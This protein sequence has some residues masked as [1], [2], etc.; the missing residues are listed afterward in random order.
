MMESFVDTV[1]DKNEQIYRSGSKCYPTRKVSVY[2]L[3][4]NINGNNKHIKIHKTYEGH[5][6]QQTTYFF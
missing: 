5:G 3:L 6:K 4:S 1:A 2:D